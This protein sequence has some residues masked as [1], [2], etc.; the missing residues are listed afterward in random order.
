M[1]SPDNVVVTPWGDVWF[2]ED[3]PGFN[4][5]VGVAPDGST[6]E[7]A[8]AAGSELAGPTFSPDGRTFFVNAQTHG[9]TFAI[10]GPFAHP[11]AGGA[12]AAAQPPARYAPIV[13]GHL[14]EAADRYGL[15]RLEAA[16]FERLGVELD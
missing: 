12:I 9:L 13:P 5:T 3:G 10:W 11:R 15:T 4:R 8:R 1:D 16:A 14:A 7:F 6:Y 2:C